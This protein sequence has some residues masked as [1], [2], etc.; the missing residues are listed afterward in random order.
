MAINS[1]NQVTIQGHVSSALTQRELAD[2]TVITQ[3]RLKVP[4]E[5]ESGSDSIPCSTLSA[6]VLKLLERAT[7]ETI[8]ETQG[9]IRS[10][11]WNSAG[12]TGSRVEVNVT[13][14]RKIKT[15]SSP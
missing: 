13:K 3:W 12:V 7:D 5:N 6:P 2:G 11:F 8:F 4:R 1:Y 15:F 10:R 14:M 9:E